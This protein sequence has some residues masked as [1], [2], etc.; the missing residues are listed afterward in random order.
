MIGCLT[1]KIKDII[2]DKVK[3][4]QLIQLITNAKEE[5]WKNQEKE[6]MFSIGSICTILNDILPNESELEDGN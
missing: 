5:V 3:C 1:M 6:L 4:L 2:I